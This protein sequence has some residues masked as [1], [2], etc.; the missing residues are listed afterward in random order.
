[1]AAIFNGS[2]LLLILCILLFSGSVVGVGSS[3]LYGD[4][5]SQMEEKVI[6]SLYTS[7]QQKSDLLSYDDCSQIS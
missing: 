2:N 6:F 3:F 4:D 1:M 7:R 5:Y